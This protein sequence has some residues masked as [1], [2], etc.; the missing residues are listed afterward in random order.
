MGKLGRALRANPLRVRG[1]ITS[2]A[3][4]SGQTHQGGA[5]FARDTKSELFLLAVTN[6][7][8]EDTFYENAA[9]R[10]TRYRDLIRAAAVADPLWTAQ[11]L[12]W[13][14]RDANMRS[15]SV[16]G[17]IEAARAISTGNGGPEGAKPRQILDSVLVRADEPGEALS[18]WLTTYGRPLPKWLTRALGDA[19][20]R[21]YNE[22]NYLKWDSDRNPIRFSDV[23]EMSQA[24]R[25]L[26]VAKEQL[27]KLILDARHGRGE[28]TPELSML[29]AN[30]KLRDAL[31]EN[32]SQM[33][34][35]LSDSQVLSQ[36]GMTWEDVLSLGGK[37]ADK[38]ALWEAAIPVMGYGA[39]IK[40]LRNFDEANISKTA[41]KQVASILTNP[42]RV[43]KSR[44]LPM[45]FL[46]AY[47]NVPSDWWK[48]VLDEAA[49]HSLSNVVRFGGRTL[50]LVDTSG[51][52][53]APFSN[54]TGRRQ[55]PGVEHLMRWDVA[56]LFGIALAKAAEHADVVSFS[57]AYW[58]TSAG[59]K[60]FPLKPGEN[61]LAAVARFRNGYFLN[62]GTDTAGAVKRW[63]RN[64][65][66]RVVILTDEQA[67]ANTYGSAVL[68]PVKASTPVYTFNL[69]GYQ[70][71]HAASGPNRYVIGGL[72]DAGFTMMAALERQQA[73]KWPWD[74]A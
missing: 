22:Y 2:E 20:L 5:G 31:A 29:T 27:F 17:A 60:E 54:T 57:D 70:R 46:N 23:I 3:T 39:L 63:Y 56:A 18:Y 59:T 52:M 12:K 71:G 38:A 32:P 19:A 72:S 30:K 69:A 1:P 6:F 66:D 9:G 24:K 35:L 74:A 11:L 33:V 68:A 8:G 7:V 50:V 25:H 37:R 40:N 47:N 55:R 10:D 44:L 43:A 36:A 65:H 67:G 4:S 42:E 41:Q 45:R 21:L 73:G 61:L 62:G 58:T 51:S 28:L 64:D 49:T 48:P 16:V 34:Q 15:A 14:R 26:G 53:N 13:L